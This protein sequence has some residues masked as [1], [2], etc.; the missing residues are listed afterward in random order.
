MKP[1][2][3]DAYNTGTYP[4]FLPVLPSTLPQD[5]EGLEGMASQRVLEDMKA[6][7]EQLLEQQKMLVGAGGGRIMVCR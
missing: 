1:T 3:L 2:A 7:H 6:R 4:S 5:W